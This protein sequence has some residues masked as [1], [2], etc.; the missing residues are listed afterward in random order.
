MWS[1]NQLMGSLHLF[2]NFRE[3]NNEYFKEMYMIEF[4]V[5][6]LGKLLIRKFEATSFDSLVVK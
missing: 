5:I 1:T 3:E 2:I 6:L 4:E